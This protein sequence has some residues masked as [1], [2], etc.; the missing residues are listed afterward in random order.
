[1]GRILYQ[2]EIWCCPVSKKF[3]PPNRN[4]IPP[5]PPPPLSKLRPNPKIAPQ[6]GVS[7][8]RYTL[9]RPTEPSVSVA[10]DILAGHAV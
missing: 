2:N 8:K 10:W 9:C 7:G 5:A 1:M 3:L 4:H 6:G